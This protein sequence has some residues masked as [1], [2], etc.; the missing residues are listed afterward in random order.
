MGVDRRPDFD[1]WF[2]ELYFHAFALTHR[3]VGD[4]AEAEDLVA[5]AFTRALDRW[6]RVGNLEYRN[7]WLI[8]V[9]TN[10]AIDVL[11]RRRRTLP[12]DRAPQRSGDVERRIL[13]V[14]ALRRLPRRQRQAV[15]LR[16][17]GQLSEL[18]TAE[19]LGVR[20]GTVKTHLRRGLAGLRIDPALLAEEGHQ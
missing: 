18:E 5:E 16:Y 12:L 1:R 15:V 4:R 11:R 6:D 20:A 19:V 3:I 17:L 8:R 13:I 14:D 9:V 2:G 7:D 10:L